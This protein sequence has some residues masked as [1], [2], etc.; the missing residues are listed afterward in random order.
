MTS[1]LQTAKEKYLETVPLLF[2]KLASKAW[3]GKGSPRSIIKAKC[4]ECVGYEKVMERVGG[5][6]VRICPLWALRPYQKGPEDLA[7]DAH[8]IAQTP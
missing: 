1:K 7:Q 4:Q 6:T 5:C 8:S 3:D 2:R